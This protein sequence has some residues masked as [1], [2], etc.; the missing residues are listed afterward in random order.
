MDRHA[1]SCPIVPERLSPGHEVATA[2]PIVIDH[3][4]EVWKGEPRLERQEGWLYKD[5]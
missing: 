4:D 2:C 5:T 1:L 3:P